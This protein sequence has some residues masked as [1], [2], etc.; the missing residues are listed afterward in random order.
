MV[1]P[2]NIH[3]TGIIL[4]DVGIVLRGPSGAGKSL[5]ALDL[6]DEAE[7][8]GHEALLV[9]DDRLDISLEGGKL[10]MA[11]PATIAGKI[12]LRGRG[13]LDLPYVATAP[14]HLVVDLVEDLARLL[15]P[16]QLVTKLQGITVARCPIPNRATIDA[17]HQ[18]LLLRAA[19]NALKTTLS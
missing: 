13:I 2:L 16:E 3:G 10:I 12:E 1:A 15:E 18:K 14:V 8:R 7:V 6:L 9:A 17:A 19:I 11:A 4:D 5:L